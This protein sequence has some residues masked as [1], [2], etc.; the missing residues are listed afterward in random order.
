MTYASPDYWNSCSHVFKTH[1]RECKPTMKLYPQSLQMYRSFS[2]AP[3]TN[4]TSEHCG[5]CTSHCRN[6][7]SQFSPAP[8]E[9]SGAV[10][11]ICFPGP[12]PICRRLR[13]SVG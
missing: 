11:A 4:L 2:W 7:S 8:F 5:H 13:L 3:T 12:G 6:I 9:V 10:S 1:R